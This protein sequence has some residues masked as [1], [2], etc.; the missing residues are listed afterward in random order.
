[1]G[2]ELVVESR[3]LAFLLEAVFAFVC[4]IVIS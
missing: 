3:T 4:W 1:M 2:W